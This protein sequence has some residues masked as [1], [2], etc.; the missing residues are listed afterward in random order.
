MAITL[1]K[2]EIIHYGYYTDDEGTMYPF[3]VEI[4]EQDREQVSIEISWDDD[5]PDNVDDIEDE[6]KEMF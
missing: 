6:L 4:S 2:S 1:D 5:Q 3:S